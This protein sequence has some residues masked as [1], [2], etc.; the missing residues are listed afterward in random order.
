LLTARDPLRRRLAAWSAE[1]FPLAL[2]LPILCLSAAALLIGRTAGTGGEVTVGLG[3]LGAFLAVWAFMFVVRV[4]DEHKDFVVDARNHPHRVLQRGLV[5]LGQ[6]RVLAAIAVAGELAVTVGF[7]VAGG[8]V[9]PVVAWSVAT[10]WL[11]L[12]T[13]EF[14]LAAYLVPRL[15]LYA[16]SH[17]ILTPLI[18]YWVMTLGAAGSA[19]WPGGAAVAWFCATSYALGAAVEVARKLRPPEAERIGVDSYTKE[20]GVRGAGT[21]VMAC[22][23]AACVCMVGVVLAVAGRSPGWVIAVLLPAALGLRAGTAFVRRPDPFTAKGVQNA[24]VVASLWLYLTA[25]IVVAMTE[26]IGW[27]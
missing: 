1:R 23:A 14:F 11:A 10:A 19:V 27:T 18:V 9:I 21:V 2:G 5:T 22:I 6:L 26:G 3:D 13:K 8:T 16:A 17:M 24:A 4:C 20:W 15:P 12:M 7:A 25:T